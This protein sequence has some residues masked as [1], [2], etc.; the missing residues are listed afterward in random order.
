M[1]TRM[2]AIIG[3][4][5]SLV[6]SATVPGGAD[7][8]INR[9]D[10]G[11]NLGIV[12]VDLT[13]GTT[14]YKRNANRAFVPA[15]NM[16]LFSDA[17][18]LMAL[19]PDYRF[20]NQLSTDAQILSGQSLQGNLY[21]HLSGDPSFNHERLAHLLAA[22]KKW[23]VKKVQGNVIIDSSLAVVDSY[24][25]GSA[26][27]DRLYGY[28]APVAPVIIDANRLVAT[29]NPGAQVG[30]VG[31]V[32]TT[33]HS[34]SITISNQIKTQGKASHCAVSLMMDKE[35]HLT[36]RGCVELG[37]W[38]IQEKMAVQNPLRYAQGSIRKQ[39]AKQGITLEG[40][41]LLGA[42]PKGTLWLASDYSKSITQLMADTLKPSDNLYADSL[43][44]HAAAKLHGQVVN[45][46]QAKII[47]KQFVQEQTGISM[48]QAVLTDGSGLSRQDLL[49]PEQT[50][51]L[52]QFLFERFPLSYEYISALPISGRDGTL[53]K[54]FKN[55]DQ[56][57]LV[58]A[59]TGTMT[60]I[61]SLSGYMS[62]K[63]RH[64]LGFAMYINTLPKTKPSI[65]GQYRSLVDSL[66]AYFLR[67]APSQRPWSTAETSLSRVKYQ[68]SPTQAEKDRTRQAKWRRLETYVKQAVKGLPVTVIYRGSELILRDNQSEPQSVFAALQKIKT[69][70]PF[71]MAVA[72][73][74]TPKLSGSFLWQERS[75]LPS[76]CQRVWI[77]RDAL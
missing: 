8:L 49:T 24:A 46:D 52:L 63:N 53:Q 71:A 16:K 33:D 60:G 31:I 64:T 35:N 44:L 77:I 75:Q 36:A 58:R 43:F 17:A 32:E 26:V 6:V 68:L 25:P 3:S 51:R 41:I 54:R 76:K 14:L 2:V 12:V 10:P 39:L 55:P 61:V 72:S 48:S 69:R 74:T 15:S 62:T 42:A 23:G 28:G 22:L 18:A 56:R 4:L 45:W 19:G 65:S 59:K 30:D 5:F 66:C 37:Q 67:Q 21:L 27:K 1:L 73:K 40:Q 57:D 47:M 7:K 34:G 38:A 29:V 11:V 13:T 9:V 50:V 20:K 70:Y